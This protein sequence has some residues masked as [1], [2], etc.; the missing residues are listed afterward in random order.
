M[1]SR[2]GENIHTHVRTQWLY[3]HRKFPEG[4]LRKMRDLELLISSP[5]PLP[6]PV[7]FGKSTYSFFYLNPDQGLKHSSL[8]F[9]QA[10]STSAFLCWAGSPPSSIEQLAILGQGGFRERLVWPRPLG[11]STARWRSCPAPAGCPC[12]PLL[13]GPCCPPPQSCFICTN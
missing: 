4:C 12:P 1:V 10:P 6:L 11:E 2:W 9:G 13:L 8:S 5:L 3:V 7:I